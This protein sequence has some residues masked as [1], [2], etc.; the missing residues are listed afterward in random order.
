MIIRKEAGRA[1]ATYTRGNGAWVRMPL[2]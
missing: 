2:C 1:Q